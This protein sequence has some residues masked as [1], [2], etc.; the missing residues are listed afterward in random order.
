M[1]SGLSHIQ[2]NVRAEN[3]PFYKD[4]FG[5]LGW[6]TIH[7][8]DGMVGLGGKNGEF[9]KVYLDTFNLIVLRGQPIQQ[10]LEEQG[11]ILQGIIDETKAACWP[12]DPKSDGP[13]KVR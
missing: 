12:P 2:F 10:V 8:A 11:K 13:C 7:E 5:F 1:Q 3:V 9:N 4:L 6:Q